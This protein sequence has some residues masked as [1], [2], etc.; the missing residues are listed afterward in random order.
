MLISIITPCYNASKYIANAIDSVLAQDYCNWEML[1][2]DDC[3]TDNSASVI[4]S[5]L[6]KDT[7]IVYIKTETNSGSATIPRNIAIEKAKGDVIAFLDSDDEWI[8]TKLSMQIKLMEE[9]KASIV[10][11]YYEKVDE[12]GTRKNRVILSPSSVDYRELLTG[13]V[14]GC[15]TAMYSV[16][17]VGKHYF[18]SVGHED[19]VMWLEILRLGGKAYCLPQVLAFY[20]VGK[21]SLSSNKLNAFRWTWSIYRN[22]EQISLFG[23]IYFFV[24]YA[25]KA[26]IKYIK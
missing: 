5:Y 1:I 20:R 24:Q 6:N 18:K 14:I 21:K 2:V 3:S 7:R 19:F 22:V 10:Y 17:R 25:F 26:A 11:S 23:S 15:L 12:V 13:N 8:P 4:N 9:Q 16:K